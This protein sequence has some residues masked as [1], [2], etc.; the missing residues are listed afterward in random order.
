MSHSL[1]KPPPCQAGFITEVI[2]SVQAC[3]AGGL[4]LKW[5][6]RPA[7]YYVAERLHDGSI[8]LQ[9]V[10]AKKIIGVTDANGR[11]HLKG[12]RKADG[13]HVHHDVD[14]S[15]R[16]VPRRGVMMAPEVAIVRYY[17]GHRT[18]TEQ[19]STAEL[20]LTGRERDI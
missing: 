14:G 1:S 17:D 4:S 8:R 13:Y 18:R 5:G 10:G 6:E 11:L 9:P 12:G 15:I 2:Y 3:P 16:L 20:S 19:I 7:E